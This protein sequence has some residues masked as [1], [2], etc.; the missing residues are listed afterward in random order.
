[1][2]IEMSGKSK[3]FGNECQYK[4]FVS[5]G[6]GLIG[7][8]INFI[9]INFYFSPF[10]AT[11]LFG[12]VLSM[13][14]T[15]AWGWK[16]GLIS[17][18]LGLGCQTMWFLWLPHSGWGSIVSVP[19]FTLWIVW[20][21]WCADRQRKKK[22]HWQNPFIMEIPFRIFNT[23]ILYTLFI[24]ACQFN[25]APWAPPSRAV[26]LEYVNFIVLKEILLDRN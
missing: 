16:Y 13:I 15:L 4:I 7:F 21:G 22:M 14:I 17:A 2:N 1:M 26:P 25:P 10:K 18:T 20:H 8:I 3:F 23:I 24:W 9:P 5:I 19:L 11:F 6:F 12:L